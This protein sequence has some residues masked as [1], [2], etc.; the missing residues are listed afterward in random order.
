MVPM[1]TS[2]LRQE[3]SV[4]VGL[5]EAV[6]IYLIYQHSMPAATSDLMAAPP[7]NT[8]VESGRKHAA[9]ES[10]ML[11]GLVLVIS[12]DLNAFIIG[13]LAL[14]GVDMSFK[15]ANAVVPGTGKADKGNGGQSIG[16]SMTH[17]LPDYTSDDASTYA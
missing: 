3:S 12:R 7:H 2:I 16:P 15:H 13:G 11:L 4:T 17:N 9:I 10:A 14:I 1:P 5:L 6:G 8:D